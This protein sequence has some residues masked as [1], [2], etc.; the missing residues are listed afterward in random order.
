M[1]GKITYKNGL[2]PSR[3]GSIVPDQK[4]YE[5]DFNQLSEY[6][7]K[8]ISKADY[9]LIV[10]FVEL[11]SSM[12]G[13]DGKTP[14]QDVIATLKSIGANPSVA[15]LGYE[16]CDATTEQQIIAALYQIGVRKLDSPTIAQV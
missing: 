14:N 6:V 10:E 11:I 9:P 12:R 8:P 4:F 13:W 1:A 5:S 2:H 16:N 7:G 15:V 3:I